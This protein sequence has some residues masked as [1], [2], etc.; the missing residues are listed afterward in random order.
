MTQ[1]EL[2]SNYSK[3]VALRNTIISSSGALDTRLPPITTDPSVPPAQPTD[4][5]DDDDATVDFN[6]INTEIDTADLEGVGTERASV[7]DPAEVSLFLNSDAEARREQQ[8]FDNF[9]RVA[10][11][12]GLGSMQSNL[13]R[14]QNFKTDSKQYSHTLASAPKYNPTL[15]REYQSPHVVE[16]QA[17]LEIKN[18]RNAAQPYF[19]NAIQNN[20]GKIPWEED[21]FRANKLLSGHF[22]PERVSSSNYRAWDNEF[23]IEHP[24]LELSRYKFK[25]TSIPELRN[26][27]YSFGLHHNKPSTQGNILY[28]NRETGYDFQPLMRDDKW[29]SKSTVK[30]SIDVSSH[31]II[32]SRM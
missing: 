11:G 8:L 6:K 29:G 26:D 14:Q 2:D 31:R 13:L 5:T 25:P 27:G 17:S 10:P 4:S 18:R 21:G 24:E 15:G 1:A 19:I 3:I 16:S 7:V 30:S 23:S 9:S 28:G 12:N 32:S 22:T 20:F